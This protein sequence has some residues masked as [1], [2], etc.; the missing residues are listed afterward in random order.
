[1]IVVALVVL[2][3]AVGSIPASLLI[4]R[5]VRGVDLRQFG[6][7]NVGAT[8]LYRAAGLPYAAGAAF[9]DIAKGYVPTF[10]FVALDGVEVPQLA[11]VY[12]GAAVLGHVFPVFAKFRGGKGVATGAGVYLALAPEAVGLAVLVWALVVAATRIV[13]VGSLAAATTLPAI[14]WLTQGSADF[15]LWSTLPLVALVWWTHRTNIVR[16]L[17]GREPRTGREAAQAARSAGSSQTG[18]QN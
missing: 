1:M 8:N 2:A 17:S 3:Y 12:G 4:A 6:S 16:L 18:G 9:F 14:V 15:V 7:G 10:L 11:L 13:S 5:Y